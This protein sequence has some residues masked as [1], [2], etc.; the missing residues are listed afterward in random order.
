MEFT[1]LGNALIAVAALHVTVRVLSR[2]ARFTTAAPRAWDSL[3]GA[4][5]IGLVVGRLW[6]MIAT[7][8]N[9][10]THLFDILLIRGGV[11]TIG[12]TVGFIAAIVWGYRERLSPAADALAAPALFG[13]AGWHGGC[14]VRDACTGVATTLP[15]GIEG[16]VGVSRHPVEIYTALLLIIAGAWSIR[17]WRKGSLA[18][19]LG[20]LG[21]VMAS[22]ARAVTEPLRL[23]L[24]SGLVGFYLFGAAAGGIL[25][26]LGRGKGYRARPQQPAE[27]A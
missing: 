18:G 23:H 25:L 1:L 13:L 17:A 2:D 22:L 8:T 27:D 11:D 10:A 4:A 19:V 9:P 7:G 14:L 20:P 5:M 6:A 12:A 26:L 16:T 15:W 21:L 3:L 24:G